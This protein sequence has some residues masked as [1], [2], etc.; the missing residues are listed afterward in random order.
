MYS[1]I[2]SDFR[3]AQ[4][5]FWKPRSRI[6]HELFRGPPQSQVWLLF[7]FFPNNKSLS[8]N[9]F[10][11]ETARRWH[12]PFF[13]PIS[14]PSLGLI[15]TGNEPQPLIKGQ[16]VL[17]TFQTCAGLFSWASR[18]G[19]S[20]GGR[21]GICKMYWKERRNSPRAYQQSIYQ[22][23]QQEKPQQIIVIATP[24]SC[25]ALIYKTCITLK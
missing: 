10:F 7:F 13:Y 17:D 20:W 12:Q 24:L 9:V 14:F 1:N 22:F 5:L 4:H 23:V 15:L 21:N 19:L 6:G 3:L 25:I 2:K 16:E 18:G 11:L 8:R